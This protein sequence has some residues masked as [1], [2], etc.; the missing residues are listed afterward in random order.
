MDILEIVVSEH[1]EAGGELVGGVWRPDAEIYH[2]IIRDEHFVWRA[3]QIIAGL[4][5]D[6]HV[7]GG[8]SRSPTQWLTYWMRFATDGLATLIYS[9]QSGRGL[10]HY[11]DTVHQGSTEDPWS[12]LKTHVLWRTL[13]EVYHVPG[14]AVPEDALIPEYR[15]KAQ[16]IWDS[17]GRD[18]PWAYCQIVPVYSRD[19]DHPD[20]GAVYAH[21]DLGFWASATRRHLETVSVAHRW[22]D[23]GGETYCLDNYQ[24]PDAIQHPWDLRA[25]AQIVAWNDLV[26]QLVAEGWEQTTGVGK[27]RMPMEESYKYPASRGL[28]PGGLRVRGRPV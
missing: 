10:W 11:N 27:F 13:T 17:Y 14:Q 16:T 21:F 3:N 6:F 5:R 4:R 25:E 7:F 1:H 22:V 19:R 9:G 18:E 12:T 28:P 24:R 23:M 20:D 8:P 2:E 26:Q 15:E